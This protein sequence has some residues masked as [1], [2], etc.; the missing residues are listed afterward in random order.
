MSRCLSLPSQ[1]KDRQA[2]KEERHSQ[3]RDDHT[4]HRN[5]T[6]GRASL[7]N[8]TFAETG[9]A[10]RAVRKNSEIARTEQPM[11]APFDSLE[12]SSATSGITTALRT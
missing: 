6:S 2:S 7:Q 11:P 12:A 8:P 3:G 9:T 10:L 5:R 4:R 1:P